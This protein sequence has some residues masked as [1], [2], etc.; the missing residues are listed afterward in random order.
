MKKKI[1]AQIMILSFAVGG[2]FV[3][4]N[5]VFADDTTPKPPGDQVGGALTRYLNRCSHYHNYQECTLR[6]NI[7]E[8]DYTLHCP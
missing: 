3:V 2:L 8:C 7:N 1:L 4:G 5:N 6:A